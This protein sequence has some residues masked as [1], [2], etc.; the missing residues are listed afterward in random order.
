MSRTRYKMNLC[1]YSSL[2][3]KELLAQNRRDIWSLSDTNNIRTHNHL[4][5][6]RI[7]NHLVELA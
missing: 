4:V 6:K 7:P 2:T 3:V 1:P 5:Q